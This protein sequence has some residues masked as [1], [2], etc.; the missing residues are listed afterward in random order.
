LKGKS[1]VLRSLAIAGTFGANDLKEQGFWG[2]KK[3]TTQCGGR[4][5]AVI[6]KEAVRKGK[7]LGGDCNAQFETLQPTG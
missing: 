7:T 2:F 5:H 3:T 4:G 6:W 1:Q